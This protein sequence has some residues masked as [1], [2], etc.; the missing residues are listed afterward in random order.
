VPF[1]AAGY[2]ATGQIVSMGDGVAGFSIG[3]FVVGFCS[4]SHS[5]YVSIHKDYLHKLPD[6]T[7]L[8]QSAL[9]VMPCVGAHALTHAGLDARDSILV[10]GQ[11]LIGQCM[12]Q[13]AR[14]RGAFVA[15]SEVS[16]ARLGLSRQYCADWAIDARTGKLPDLIRDR[17]PNGFD[18]VAESTGF[19]PL[20]EDAMQCVKAGGFNRG[21]KFIFLGWYPDTISLQV[22]PSP[23]QAV[24][25]FLS[26]LHRR[27]AEPGW[28]SETH[29]I[30]SPQDRPAD[31]PRRALA[32]R[33][34][35]L[36]PPLHP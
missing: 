4:C 7:K 26:R 10:V 11:G 18:L 29:R 14:L 20:I 34:R 31:Q 27:T 3:E 35:A 24:A 33:G 8:K 30:R 12:A 36:Q 9:F 2:Q 25:M 1:P 21:G 28:G 13:L 15:T 32:R 5:Q 16:P 17:F 6:P 19:Q 23:Q 22:P